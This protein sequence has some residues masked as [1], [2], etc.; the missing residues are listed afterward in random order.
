MARK[1]GKSGN[2]DPDDTESFTVDWSDW[3][4]ITQ[5]TIVDC[6]V[7]ADGLEVVDNPFTQTDT[8]AV[9]AGGG[10]GSDHMVVFRVRT[11]AGYV[12]NRTLK[13]KINDL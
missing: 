10:A 8:T 5:D 12:Y 13:I 6:D 7:F 4:R 1:I 2:K 11:A 3:L 9:L